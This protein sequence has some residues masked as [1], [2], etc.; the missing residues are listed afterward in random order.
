LGYN[1]LSSEWYKESYKI[2][3]KKYD[4]PI[5]K[6]KKEKSNFLIKKFKSLFE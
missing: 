3:N 1:Y 2:F 5:S 6:I 4:D